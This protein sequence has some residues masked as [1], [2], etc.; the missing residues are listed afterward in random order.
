MRELGPDLHEMA[1][2]EWGWFGEQRARVG[3]VPGIASSAKRTILISYK[4]ICDPYAPLCSLPYAHT[5]FYLGKD[6]DFMIQ[7][8]KNNTS[9]TLEFS[10]I[11]KH[12]LVITHT[13]RSR[14]LALG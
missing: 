4:N 7:P 9:L 11:S 2:Q 13:H 1:V 10:S 6:D 12:V 8:C 14:L 3:L 5:L